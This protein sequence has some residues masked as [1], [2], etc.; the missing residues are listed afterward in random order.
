MKTADTPKGPATP[1]NL[2]IET[3]GPALTRA[4][5][6]PCVDTPPNRPADTPSLWIVPLNLPDGD[7][8]G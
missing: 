6:C 2:P 7:G 3:A 1:E 8:H 4:A 5:P